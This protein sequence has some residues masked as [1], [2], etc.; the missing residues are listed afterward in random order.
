MPAFNWERIENEKISLNLTVSLRYD[1]GQERYEDV[2]MTNFDGRQREYNLTVGNRITYLAGNHTLAQ[3]IYYFNSWNHSNSRSKYRTLMPDGSYYYEEENREFEWLRAG[4]AGIYLQ[5]DFKV[6]EDKFYLNFGAISEVFESTHEYTLCPR[7]G[8]K[9]FNNINI[10]QYYYNKD[11]S[12]RHEATMLTLIPVFGLRYNFMKINAL[13]V[14]FIFSILLHFSVVMIPAFRS[15]EGRIDFRKYRVVQ[16]VDLEEEASRPREV[17]KKAD[18]EIKPQQ[19]STVEHPEIRIEN[20]TPSETGTDEGQFSIYLP[21]FRVMR[22][23]E[24]KIRKRP[25][26]PALAKIKGLEAEVLSEVYIDAEGL[27][28]K[29]MIVKSGGEDFDKATLESLQQSVFTPAL[30][31]EGQP[32]PVR[33]RIPFKFELD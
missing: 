32:V 15:V 19:Q 16:L 20:T 12:E 22:L 23:P 33:V 7:G 10:D 25:V 6:V 1:Q 27:P 3:G 14:S 24:F 29:V 26:Y 5:D 11:Y 28:R 2:K 13:Q 18:G 31:K 21:F 4:A 9:Y 17:V 30:S 8:V